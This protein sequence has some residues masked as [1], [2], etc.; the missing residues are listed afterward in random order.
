MTALP[1]KSGHAQSGHQCLLSAISGHRANWL[2]RSEE[3]L[4]PG[5]ICAAGLSQRNRDAK[6][7]QEDSDAG[8]PQTRSGKLEPFALQV[9]LVS[10]HL[11]TRL[12]GTYAGA[13]CF[14]CATQAPRARTQISFEP[15]R[16]QQFSRKRW[17]CAPVPWRSYF[18]KR[19]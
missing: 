5:V 18:D 15:A 9:I 1:L 10:R 3:P 11:G 2:G 4:P 14:R 19:P 17:E 8:D 16:T 6:D 13:T 7:N 12:P